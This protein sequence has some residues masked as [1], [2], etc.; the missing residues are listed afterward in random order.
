[1]QITLRERDP[2]SRRWETPID[3]AASLEAPVRLGMFVLNEASDIELSLHGNEMFRAVRVIVG[4]VVVAS[5]RER[6]RADFPITAFDEGAKER[7]YCRGRLLRDWVGLA[8]F[9]IDAEDSEGWRPVLEIVPL[10]IRAGKMAQEEFAALCEE[11]A[12]HSAGALLDVYGKTFFGLELEFRPGEQ[13][14]VAA[15]QRVRQAIDQMSNALRE[16]ATQP[17]YRLRTRRVREPAMVVQGVS[18]LTLEEACI[19]PTLVIRN[20]GGIAFREHVREVAVPHFNLAENRI[21]SGFLRFLELQLADLE[22]RLKG[23]IQLR[24]E[25]RAIHHRPTGDG[26]KTWW[27]TEDQPRIT[28]LKKLVDH[29]LVMRTDL[30]RLTRHEFLPKGVELRE[31]PL[32]TPLLRSNRAYASAFRTVLSHFKSFRVRLGE[33]HLLTRGKSL[34]VLYEWWCVLEVLRILQA[35][36]K[37]CDNQPMGRGSPF[38]RLEAERARF[39]V[40]FEPDQA[41][42]FEDDAGRLVRMR[43]VPSYRP[44]HASGGLA[45]GLL[46]PEEERTPDIA[47]E[48]F[49]AGQS[50]DPIPEFL[51]IFD[52]KYSSLP[53]MRKLEEVRLKYGKIGRFE[54]GQVLSRQVWALVPTPTFSSRVTGPEWSAQCTIDNSGFWSE[55]YDMQST[56]T[57]VIQAKPGLELQRPPL[58]GLIRL[59]LRRA[60]V[61]VRL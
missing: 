14:P 12:R 11:V 34:P 40:E 13:A 18:D 42:D 4:D 53:H 57:G 39:V 33:D 17:A 60:G 9:R 30:R 32:S 55:K 2:L 43:Y 7:L 23:E 51:M 29:L 20:R 16:I 58:E 41:V 6:D 5:T 26:E 21:L 24:D 44:E 52:A 56:T 27:E 47:L 10:H 35:S 19:D 37:L 49:P 15:L 50:G 22:V 3:V 59:L 46:G 25:R 28:E 31:I 1:M 36:L 38:R 54:T 61:A 48:V 8:E 45:F